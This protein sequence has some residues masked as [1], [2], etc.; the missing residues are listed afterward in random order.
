LVDNNDIG[1]V[2]FD[3]DGI[4]KNNTIIGGRVAIGVAAATR[5]ATELSSGDH[6]SG[7]SDSTTQTFECCGFHASVTVKP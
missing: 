5:D 2:V 3:A 6:I 7:V 1:L 4:T